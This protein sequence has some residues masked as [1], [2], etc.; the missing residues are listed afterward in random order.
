MIQNIVRRFRSIKRVLRNG[1][2]DMFSGTIVINSGYM[3]E[4]FGK[5]FTNMHAQVSWQTNS[6][7]KSVNETEGFSLFKKFLR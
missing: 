1:K 7:R 2:P 5:R 4:S 6:T 3:L